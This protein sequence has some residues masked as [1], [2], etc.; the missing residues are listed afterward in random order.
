MSICKDR[1]PRLRGCRLRSLFF[2]V[3]FFSSS[4]AKPAS[5]S[6]RKAPARYFARQHFIKPRQPS[7]DSSLKPSDE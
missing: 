2:W 7:L 6:S 5:V 1:N 4:G 3:I